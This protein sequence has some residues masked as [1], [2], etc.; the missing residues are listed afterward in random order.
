MTETTA[1]TLR[2]RILL[3]DDDLGFC[4]L[5]ET[6]LSATSEV[7]TAHD[8]REALT[9]GR[10]ERPD[11]ILLDVMMPRLD[12]TSAGW[13]FANDPFF[14]AVPV[15]FCTAHVDA[16][17]K[18][19]MRLIKPFSLVDLNT[20]ISGALLGNHRLAA[21]FEG[22]ADRF[23]PHQLVELDATLSIAPKPHRGCRVQLLFLWGAVVDVPGGLGN[24]VELAVDDG[25][26]VTLHLDG[27]IVWSD[28][29]RSGLRFHFR[30]ESQEE[31]Y[32]GLLSRVSNPAS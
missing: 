11:V 19:E 4:E 24:S 14:A 27:R 22:E 21:A 2:P 16:L 6:W 1:P 9:M 29:E 32:A 26:G 8:G 10:L 23:G 17:E 7:V 28:G 3:V 31:S 12:G 18:G 5:L 13:L 15:I 20:A 25:A 30:S